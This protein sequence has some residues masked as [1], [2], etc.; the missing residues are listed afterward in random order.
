MGF[1]CQ[2]VITDGGVRDVPDIAPGFQMLAASV[3]P[4]HAFVHVVDYSRPVDVAGMRVTD[5]D[6]IH[7]DQHGAVVI[8]AEVIGQ[9]QAAAE[10]LAR[11]EAVII[12]AAQKP[13][14]DIDKL[15]AA[16]GE[17]AEIH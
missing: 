12:S 5:G 13:D 15:R 16:Q 10:Q 7:A 1:G 11:R 9:V 2:G 4:S 8:P 17:S 14:F 6:I 3:L